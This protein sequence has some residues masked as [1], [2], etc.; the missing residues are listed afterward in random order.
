MTD[1]HAIVM[2]RSMILWIGTVVLIAFNLFAASQRS[3]TL[4]YAALVAT[5]LFALFGIGFGIWAA[6]TIAR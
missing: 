4:T 2:R 1:G 3:P 5:G 6:R